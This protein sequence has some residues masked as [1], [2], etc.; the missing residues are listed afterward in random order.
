MATS[1]DE[2][3]H[4]YEV[5]QNCFNKIANKQPGWCRYL[6]VIGT[7]D[8]KTH[9]PAGCVPGHFFIKNVFIFFHHLYIAPRLFADRHVFAHPRVVIVDGPGN[10]SGTLRVLRHHGYARSAARPAWTCLKILKPV[11]SSLTKLVNAD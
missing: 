10:Y 2:P 11:N 1:D 7:E 9:R 8:V 4:L 5:F 3:M 6:I